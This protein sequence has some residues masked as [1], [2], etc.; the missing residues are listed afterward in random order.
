MAKHIFL[1]QD[2]C[3]LKTKSSVVEKNIQTFENDEVI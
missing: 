2:G 3:T 1:S